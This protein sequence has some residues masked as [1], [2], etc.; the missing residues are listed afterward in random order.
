MG[1]PDDAG[2]GSANS[3]GPQSAA[4]A[5]TAM[6]GR[7]VTSAS[8]FGRG[9]SNGSRITT[10]SGEWIWCTESNAP[11]GTRIHA[12]TR[13][14]FSATLAGSSAEPMPMFKPA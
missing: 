10:T 13:R 8:A 4:E 2:R 3:T 7:S 1:R 6:P 11:A 14:L 5:Q 9:P 12:A